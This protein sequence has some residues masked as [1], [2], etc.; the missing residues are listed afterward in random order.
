[1]GGDFLAVSTPQI[2]LSCPSTSES[3]LAD[4]NSDTVVMR[5]LTC[6]P[7]GFWRSWQNEI[8]QLQ[9]DWR[10]G[11]KELMLKARIKG[12]AGSRDVRALIDTGAKAPL[13]FRKG[14][15]PHGK[16]KAAKFPVSFTTADGQL[17]SSVLSFYFRDEVLPY[18]AGDDEAAQF[19]AGVTY[20][21]RQVEELV[22][23]GVPGIHFY[24]LNK[25]PATIRV[26]DH[27]GLKRA[28][29]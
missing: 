7:K 27:V 28:G 29:A 5:R 11:F 2:R 17:L 13:V 10:V 18:Y 26:L 22:A 4:K 25:S 21:A 3:K 19:E 1:M 15:F 20:A 14:L 6:D 23:A 12:H 9:R 24:V 16:L 8:L